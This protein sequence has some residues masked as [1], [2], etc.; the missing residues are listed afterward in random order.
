MRSG[1]SSSAP[2]HGLPRMRCKRMTEC[3]NCGKDISSDPKE[4]FETRFI[5]IRKVGQYS[6]LSI[7]LFGRLKE[8]TPCSDCV[9]I[10]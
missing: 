10:E 3:V 7:S 2:G 1:S 8:D 5:R 4:N 6:L 9:S